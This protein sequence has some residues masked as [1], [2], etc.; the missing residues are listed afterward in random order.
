MAEFSRSRHWLGSRRLTLLAAVF[1]LVAGLLVLG[2]RPGDLKPSEGGLRLAGEFLKAAFQPALDYESGDLPA[3]APPFWENVGRSLLLTLRY[4]VVAMSMALGAGVLLG[5]LGSRAW[6]PVFNRRSSS[7]RI[8]LRV[9]KSTRIVVRLLATLARS[10]HELLWALLFITAVGT[11]PLAAVLAI[12]LPY[13]G[14]LAKVFSELLDEQEASAAAGLCGLPGRI[15]CGPRPT[16]YRPGVVIWDSEF[17]TSAY[18]LR[19]IWTYLMSS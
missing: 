5:V 13:G 6:W 1:L 18:D 2:A 7:G 15:G 14:T 12:A 4:A 11:S 3:T 17:H 16:L 9:L 8:L 10:V 19:E